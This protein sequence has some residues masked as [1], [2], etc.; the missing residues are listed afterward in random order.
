MNFHPEP[1]EYS[2]IGWYL[3]SSKEG[4]LFNFAFI[5]YFQQQFFKLIPTSLLSNF[6]LSYCKFI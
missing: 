2:I 5:K 3:L 1:Q 6:E 4:Q